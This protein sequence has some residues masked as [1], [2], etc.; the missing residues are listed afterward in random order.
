MPVYCG[1][2]CTSQISIPVFHPAS[3]LV[4]VSVG[5]QECWFEVS[6]ERL[7]RLHKGDLTKASDE[8]LFQSRPLGRIVVP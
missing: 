5:E 3:Y 1:D 7:D 6:K 8:P 4:K 2:N